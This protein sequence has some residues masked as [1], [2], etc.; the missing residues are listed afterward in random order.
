MDIG[1]LMDEFVCHGHICRALDTP[2]YII[3][4]RLVN[5]NFLTTLP[6]AG[7]E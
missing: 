7:L 4:T 6:V 5:T 3:F 1:K 2:M